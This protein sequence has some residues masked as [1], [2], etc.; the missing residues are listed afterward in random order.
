VIDLRRPIRS[1]AVRRRRFLVAAALG[2]AVALGALA[3]AAWGGGAVVG[4]PGAFNATITAGTITAGTAGAVKNQSLIGPG[5]PIRIQGQVAAD[6]TVTVPVSGVNFPTIPVT[7]GGISATIDLTATDPATGRI[8]PRTGA[9]T[10]PLHLQLKVSIPALKVSCLTPAIDLQLTTGTS[11]T[12]TG[13]AYNSSTGA[14]SMVDGTFSVPPFGDTPRL[15]TIM[16]SAIGLPAQTGNSIELTGALNPI[17]VPPGPPPPPTPPTCQNETV[18]TDRNAPVA[19]DLDCTGKVDSRAIV[20]GPAHGTLGPIDQAAG[21]V[22]YTPAAGYIGP[23]SFTY[24]A[25]NGSAVS[26]TRT[27]SITVIELPPSCEDGVVIV[28]PFEATTTIPFECTGPEPRT[29]GIVSGPRHGTL[30]AIDQAN[31]Q[32]D[33]SPRPRYAGGDAFRFNARDVGGVSNPAIQRI[34][35]LPAPM[36]QVLTTRTALTNGRVP[37]R[38]LCDSQV[39]NC[40]GRLTLTLRGTTTVVGTASYSIVSGRQATVRVALSAAGR[41]LARARPA[42]TVRARTATRLPDGGVKRDSGLVRVVTGGGGGGAFTG[43]LF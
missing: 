40:A 6:G 22:T 30:S 21:R 34:L 2:A 35:V 17:V 3:P 14:F 27:V 28:D 20:T 23:D 29:Y 19:V 1:C 32:V 31:A 33:Y 25:R 18:R 16:N 41:R 39:R 8:V 13:S 11:G 24:N 10:L 37:I 15:C 4:N 43:A 36:A 42:I 9:L 26:E 5:G 12:Q 7:A 38:L